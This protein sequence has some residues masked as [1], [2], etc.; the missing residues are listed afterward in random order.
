M[1]LIALMTLYYL[2][3]QIMK[4]AVCVPIAAFWD[5]TAYPDA[6]CL[7]Q[8]KLLE[9]DCAMSLPVD[10]AILVLPVYLACGLPSLGWGKKLRIAGMLGAGGVAISMSAYRMVLVVKFS[11]STDPTKD[12]VMLDVTT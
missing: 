1:F 8:R 5:T 11:D 3:I 7:D 9:A 12:V 4:M 10:V 6:K 2:P